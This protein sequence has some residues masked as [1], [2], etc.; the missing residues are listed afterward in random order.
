MA[1]RLS[2]VVACL[3][4]LGFASA[5]V[6]DE[7]KKPKWQ[8]P[9]KAWNP[10][11]AEHLTFNEKGLD[12]FNSLS[13]EQRQ[14]WVEEMKQK[15][16]SFVGQAIYKQGA[17]LGEKMDDYALGTYEIVTELPEPILYE[18]T[19]NYRLYTTPEKGKGI[20][21]N[22][23]IEFKGTLA[24]LDYQSESKPRKIDLKIKADEIKVLGP[25]R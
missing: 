14:A 13:P 1:R 8:A 21:P 24:D 16:G 6:P 17:E 11:G 3:V 4:A 7:D 10:K 9:P 23:Y 18:I 12:A 19:L 5:C 2:S 22:A 15:P 20:P 25:T